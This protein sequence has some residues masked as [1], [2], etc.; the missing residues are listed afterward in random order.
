MKSNE[1]TLDDVVNTLN[2]PGVSAPVGTPGLGNT[3]AYI[4]TYDTRVSRDVLG[5]SYRSKEETV[6]AI[7]AS[8]QE[9]GYSFTTQ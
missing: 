5:L 7:I 6:T 8:L 9:K 1:F 4:K 2:I 3:T